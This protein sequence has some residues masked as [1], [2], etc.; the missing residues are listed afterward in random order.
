MSGEKAVTETITRADALRLMHERWGD[1][2]PWVHPT[3][4]AIGYYWRIGGEVVHTEWRGRTLELALT[5]AGLLPEES[6]VKNG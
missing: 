6:G 1:K 3:E 4:N 2:G 5:A